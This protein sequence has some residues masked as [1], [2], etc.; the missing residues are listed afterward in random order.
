MDLMRTVAA[1]GIVR[2]HLTAR[3]R[4]EGHVAL[5]PFVIPAA[6]R[7]LRSLA[8]GGSGCGG[9]CG[10]GLSRRRAMDYRFGP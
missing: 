8:R 5:G 6:L 2:G 7:S 9:W 10:S 1:F 3:G 4:T